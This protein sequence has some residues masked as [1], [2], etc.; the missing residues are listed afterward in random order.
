MVVDMRPVL[1]ILI[2]F[3]VITHCIIPLI[4]S[5]LNKLIDIR[6][7]AT[8]AVYQ[9]VNAEEADLFSSESDEDEEEPV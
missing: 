6:V 3:C 8:L 4:R 9:P 2:S 1:L 5:G 7:R